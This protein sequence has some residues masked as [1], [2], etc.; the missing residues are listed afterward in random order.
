M[1]PPGAP[2]T[3]PAGKCTT[4]SVETG[5]AAGAS[6]SD[7]SLDARAATL[8]RLRRSCRAAGV[9]APAVILHVLPPFY[10]AAAPGT[11]PLTRAARALGRDERLAVRDFYPFITDAS[12]VAWRGQDLEG[13]AAEFP[14]LGREYRLPWREASELDLDVVNLGPWGRDAHGLFERV[15]ADFA[16]ER[17]PNL[18]VRL[19]ERA[20]E[21]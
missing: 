21:E 19:I 15:R 7:G 20:F 1:R 9:T 18:I 3:Q 10:P 13:L 4:A 14:A 12:Y 2:A 11:G 5:A 6:A 17:L 16:F 8:S